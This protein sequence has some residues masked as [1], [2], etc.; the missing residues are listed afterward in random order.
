FYKEK[1]P[2]LIKQLS[3]FV[4]VSFAWIFFRARNFGDAILIV[5]R[6]FSEKPANPEF[7]LIALLLCVSIWI[8]Q[9]FYESR[10]KKFL[11][12]APVR[13]GIMIFI[14]LCLTI[15]ASAGQDAFIY[16]QF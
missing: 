14:L 4:F 10:G 3:V 12:L 16:F 13:V 9:F 8:Y 7:P 5:K 11:E 15:F 2:R 1:V 6:I